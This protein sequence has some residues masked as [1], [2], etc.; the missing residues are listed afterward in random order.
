MSVSCNIIKFNGLTRC[1]VTVYMTLLILEEITDA[2][3]NTLLT[4]HN[5]LQIIVS[6]NTVVN[7][8]NFIGMFETDSCLEV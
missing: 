6:Y 8:L 4:F 1:R 5:K 7:K 2:A 3:V